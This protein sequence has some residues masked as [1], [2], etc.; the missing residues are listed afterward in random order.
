[1][2]EQQIKTT[3]IEV[4]VLLWFA[5]IIGL[6]L[7]HSYTGDA[8]PAY[9]VGVVVAI[10][11]SLTIILLFLGY[12][13]IRSLLIQKVV[14]GEYDLII[15]AAAA[16]KKIP[17]LSY[18]GNA[19]I[20]WYLTVLVSISQLFWIPVVLLIM[21]VTGMIIVKIKM[22]NVLKE[23]QSL[24]EDDVKLLRELASVMKTLDEINKE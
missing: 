22:R 2:E 9:I 3:K 6:I 8:I 24:S 4:P 23:V 20:I 15:T 11:S 10:E 17:W 1:M 7:I 21:H 19:F 5:A 12:H 13:G 14:D 18:S 16:N